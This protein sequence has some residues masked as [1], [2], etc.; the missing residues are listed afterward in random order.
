MLFI[1]SD[2]D[3]RRESQATELQEQEVALKDCIE[4]LKLAEANRSS[5]LSQLKEAM[6]K[7]VCESQLSVFMLF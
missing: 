1:L 6:W 5:L 4:R 3:P 7:Q 2:G